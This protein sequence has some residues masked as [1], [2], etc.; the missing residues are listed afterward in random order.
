MLHLAWDSNGRWRYIASTIPLFIDVVVEVEYNCSS[1]V[2][3]LSRLKIGICSCLQRKSTGILYTSCG[4]ASLDEATNKHHVRVIIVSPT[5]YIWVHGCRGKNTADVC[6][7]EA[8]CPDLWGLA[9]ITGCDQLHEASLRK[10]PPTTRG[11]LPKSSGFSAHPCAI[12]PQLLL[13][14]NK[15]PAQ[16]LAYFRKH[17]PNLLLVVP[18]RLLELLSIILNFRSKPSFLMRRTD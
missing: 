17:S 3:S 8:S 5:R 16:D 11:A 4:E 15:T 9:I 7:I 18:G 1:T 2:L 6:V 14:W 12:V 13:G 10:R